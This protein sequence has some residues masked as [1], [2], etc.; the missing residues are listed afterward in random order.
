M[1]I[2]P[3]GADLFHVDGQTERQTDR[4][5]DRQDETR[6]VFHNFENAPKKP[7]QL[8]FIVI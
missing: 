2:H 1:K 4:Q 5:I 8:T 7:F 3:V 6:V